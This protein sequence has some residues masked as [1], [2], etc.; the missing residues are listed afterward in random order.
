M[1]SSLY[2]QS[3]RGQ[4]VLTIIHSSVRSMEAKRKWYFSVRE[5]KPATSLPCNQKMLRQR[6]EGKGSTVECGQEVGRQEE[7]A[8]CNLR[9]RKCCPLAEGWTEQELL[10]LKVN[11]LLR[12]RGPAANQS[13]AYYWKEHGCKM[14]LQ[15][16]GVRRTGCLPFRYPRSYEQTVPRPRNCIC[17]KILFCSRSLPFLFLMSLKKK[18]KEEIPGRVI[19]VCTNNWEYYIWELD[20]LFL[21]PPGD[22]V[23]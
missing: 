13:W 14:C 21:T 11:Q 6:N 19:K 15:S 12:G 23:G 8:S 16:A 9:K 4:I 1:T 5:T 18:E 2:N 17:P 7:H 20:C 3:Y 22:H 10:R